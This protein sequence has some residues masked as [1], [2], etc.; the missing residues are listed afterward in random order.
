MEIEFPSPHPYIE[1]FIQSHTAMITGINKSIGVE[2]CN[3][4]IRKLFEEKFGGKQIIA[5][6]TVRVVDKAHELSIK[7]DLY[8]KKLDSVRDILLSFLRLRC[9]TTLMMGRKERLLR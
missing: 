9:R 1:S 6:H 8:K 2:E 3:Y 5:V 4:E 7:R